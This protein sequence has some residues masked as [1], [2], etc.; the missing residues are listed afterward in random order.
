MQAVATTPAGTARAT[1]GLSVA[2]ALAQTTRALSSGG[3]TTKLTV[4]VHRLADPVDV[5]ITTDRIVGRIDHD[6]LVVLVGSILGNPVRVQHAQTS[7]TTS[8]TFL[9]NRLQATVRLELV[10]TVALGL[11]VSATL[12]N[13]ALAASA[14]HTDAEDGIALL[15]LVAQTAGLVRSRRTR[16]TVE[17]RHLAILP[18]ADTQQVAHH[19]ALLL[20][21]QLLYVSVRTHGY[22]RLRI[23]P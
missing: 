1:N 23:R 2:V 9:S 22:E 19:I 17:S 16:G 5:R 6:D 8:N 13:R 7:D 3:K 15:R 21:V 11:A 10:D 18:D 12:G 20:A 14:A 4:L